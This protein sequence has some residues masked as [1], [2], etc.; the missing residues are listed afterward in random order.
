MRKFKLIVSVLL[1]MCFVLGL[2]GCPNSNKGPNKIPEK[3]PL[4]EKY[5]DLG[6]SEEGVKLSEEESE[7]VIE[8]LQ[9]AGL[10]EDDDYTVIRIED[11]VQIILTEKGKEKLEN[12]VKAESGEI[13]GETISIDIS[14]EV[15]LYSAYYYEPENVYT[16][17]FPIDTEEVKLG[18]K[19]NI[20]FKATVSTDI[21]L[22]EAAVFYK[23]GRKYIFINTEDFVDVKKD[24]KAGESFEATFD[25][26]VNKVAVPADK[27]LFIQ[28]RLST[29]KAYDKEDAIIVENNA[30]SEAPHF[31]AE[32]V[33]KGIKIT[34]K[35]LPGETRNRDSGAHFEFV[36]NG[37]V[38]PVTIH[39]TN[40]IK[41]TNTLLY[42]FVSKDDDVYISYYESYTKG[43][44]SYGSTES[45]KVTATSDGLKISDYVDI[46]KYNLI[47]TKVKYDDAK[48]MFYLGFDANVSQQDI[49]TTLAIAPY[50][51]SF[52]LC[53]GEKDWSSTDWIGSNYSSYVDGLT[54][55]GG[56]PFFEYGQKIELPVTWMDI[57]NQ[58][59]AISKRGNKYWGELAL[60]FTIDGYEG[61]PYKLPTSFSEYY[62]LFT[63]DVVKDIDAALTDSIKNVK[64]VPTT[65]E[66]LMS[67]ISQVV[68]EYEAFFID[69]D[70]TQRSVVTT[71]KKALTAIEIVEQTKSFVK[72]F[73]EEYESVVSKSEKIQEIVVDF[74][75]QINVG[76]VPFTQW[77]TA[78]C[79]IY[80]EV[81]KLMGVNIT[82]WGYE[83]LVRILSE[84]IGI[85]ASEMYKL[86]DVLDK[87]ALVE[88]LYLDMDVDFDGKYLDYPE[89][90]QAN[91][92]KDS[93]LGSVYLGY[94]FS[95][96]ISDVNGLFKAFCKESGM[97]IKDIDLPVKAIKLETELETDVKAT[98]GDLLSFMGNETDISVTAASLLYENTC[99][100]AVCTK[101]NNGGLITIKAKVNAD[102]ATAINCIK[103]GLEEEL[104]ID[105]I[106]EDLITVS[107]SVSD[108]SSVVKFSNEYS[109]KDVLTILGIESLDEL[110]D[111]EEPNEEMDY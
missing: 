30:P 22:V 31:K 86:L 95:V 40:D 47:E 73:L 42:P 20:K 43:S 34:L 93:Q 59:K 58:L 57:D 54:C 70:E 64:S 80:D 10:V 79:E 11:E 23:D 105:S 61:T 52:Q 16:I 46:E 72:A 63:T 104:S 62:T 18:D 28:F 12:Q 48:G 27:D 109:Y 99:N 100:I 89:W 5:D 2:L 32:A 19:L 56:V 1:S 33:D 110:F 81:N 91:A 9:N 85:S 45:V 38:K 87:Y 77:F 49:F 15:F 67:L 50:V 75:K 69:E 90:T 6:I 14:N 68:T 25:Y 3:T 97:D 4:E 92:N 106:L 82:D 98:Y 107:L 94:L 83:S 103:E 44:E 7:K 96:G 35:E 53:A 39:V 29:G 8:K 66:E 74:D 76:K 26:V 51:A 111:A 36:V 17:D 88:K 71:G 78:L 24:V 13:T 108:A 65:E 37:K 84:E 60:A 102:K 21:A 55:V 101:D 41:G